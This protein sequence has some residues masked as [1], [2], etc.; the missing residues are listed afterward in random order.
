MKRTIGNKLNDYK[1]L[2]P[3]GS[4]FLSRLVMIRRASNVVFRR[5]RLAWLNLKILFQQRMGKKHPEA[6]KKWPKS[7]II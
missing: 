5:N 4:E 7:K 6:V 3:P 1:H 2:K